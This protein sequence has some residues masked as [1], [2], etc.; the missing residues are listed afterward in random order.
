MRDYKRLFIWQKGMDI[1]KEVCKVV[2]LLPNEDKYRLRSRA[3]RAA[4]SIVINIAEGS[5]KASRRE[6]RSYAET[7]RGSVFELETVC[8]LIG[9]LNLI[10]KN[11]IDGLMNE[12][13]CEQRM[14]NS[15]ITQL[16]SDD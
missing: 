15:F 13:L 10:D 11:I 5:T 3:K 1:T 7:S 9:R 8:R 14:I 2:S 6:Y 4:V 16:K 12:L